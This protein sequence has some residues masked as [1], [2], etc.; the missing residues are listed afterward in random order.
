MSARSLSAPLAV[1]FAA[2]LTSRPSSPQRAV[3]F[4][5]PML[6]RPDDYQAI[7]NRAHERSQHDPSLRYRVVDLSTSKRLV[8]SSSNAL[9]NMSTAWPGSDPA[10]A[11]NSAMPVSNVTVG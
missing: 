10:H 5:E 1:T 4:S 11:I 6:Q 3:S 2:C 9:S 8:L 7:S